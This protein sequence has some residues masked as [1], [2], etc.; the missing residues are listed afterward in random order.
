MFKVS[1]VRRYKLL[2]VV[3]AATLGVDGLKLIVHHFKLELFGT[4]PLF[5][6]LVTATVFLLG[7]LLNG[8]LSDYKESEKLPGD[9]STSLEV[10]ALELRAAAIRHPEVD[11]LTAQRSLTDLVQAILNWLYQRIDTAAMMRA[12]YG[13]H[14]AIINAAVRLKPVDAGVSMGLQTRMAAELELGF[15]VLNRIETIRE[16]SFV[17]VVY[18]LAYG[19]YTLLV[20]GLVFTKSDKLP[21]Q[22]F[23]ITVIAFVLLFLLRLIDDLD[24]PFGLGDP[25]SAEDVSVEVLQATHRR[26]QFLEA[27]TEASQLPTAQ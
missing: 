27:E 10:I 11:V 3:F 1:H 7:F 17:P 18:W 19:G 26:L 24:N 23:F 21:E 5:S 22:I 25:D 20:A 15:K 12:L 6:A 13:S 9:L 2:L 16:T 8:V 4:N 14:R